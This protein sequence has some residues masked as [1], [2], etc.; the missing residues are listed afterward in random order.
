MPIIKTLGFDPYWFCAIFLINMEL[1]TISPPYGL[2]LFT[3]K[4]VA[5][6]HTMGD[7][8][9]ASIPFCILDTLALILVM[10]FPSIALFIPHLFKH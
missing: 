1:A 5:P 10:T 7:V 6:H 8:F 3:M 4:G 9:K 2:V